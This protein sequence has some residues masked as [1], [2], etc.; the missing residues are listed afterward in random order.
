MEPVAAE[1]QARRE[2]NL[3]EMNDSEKA[4]AGQKNIFEKFFAF[5][6]IDKKLSG[7]SEPVAEQNSAPSEPEQNPDEQI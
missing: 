7:K 4:K 6:G 2:L 5:T 3:P 1:E